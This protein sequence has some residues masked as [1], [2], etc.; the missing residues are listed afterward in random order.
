MKTLRIGELAKRSGL[1]VETLRYYER[2]GLIPSP[3]RLPSGYRTYPEQTLDR[4]IFI[5]RSKELGFSLDEI[6][7]LLDLEVAG[8][9]S[10]SDVKSR[11]DN[12]IEMVE[13]KIADLKRLQHSLQTLSGLCCGEGSLSDC[14]IL[15]Y[16]HQPESSDD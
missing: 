2:R 3:E 9:V 12:K 13:R 11:V 14:P 4:L 8:D 15:E 6:V 7:E 10:A 5:R 16:L 1:S